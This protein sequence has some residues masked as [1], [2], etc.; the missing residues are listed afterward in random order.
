[1]SFG[2]ALTYLSFGV[3]GSGKSTLLEAIGSE[4]LQRDLPIIDLFG[5]RDGESLAWL[6]SPWADEK[7]ILLLHGDN[8]SV[9]SCHDSKPITQ[10][11]L[12]DIETYDI[13]ISSS[14]LYSSL[15]QEYKDVNRII[16]LVYQRAVWKRSAYICIREAAN[17]LY[18]R[19]KISSDQGLAKA[20]LIYFLREARHCGFSLGLDTQK[21]TSIDLD[22]RITI[23]YLFFKSLGI[24]GLP[25]DLRFLYRTYVPLRLQDMPANTYLLLTKRGSHGIGIFPYHKWHKRPGENILKSV[26]VDVE[27]GEELVETRP[28][29]QI[30]DLRHVEIV[31]MRL[32][33]YAYREIAEKLDLSKSTP[34]THIHKHNEEV[35]RLGECQQCKRAKSEHSTRKIEGKQPS[36]GALQKPPV[37]TIEQPS[38]KEK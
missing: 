19:M 20:F 6:R 5:S 7:R 31:E 32:E 10:Y 8:T 16:D 24:Q 9:A 28:N 36:H 4:Y 34:W 1:M 26:G 35:G 21:M 30:G 38:S 22:V 13:I 29:Y 27:H 23:D 17:L 3:R 18:S 15:D 11:S 37:R 2:G 12:K 25:N 33:G 14:P